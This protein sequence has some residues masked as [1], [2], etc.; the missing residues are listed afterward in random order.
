MQYSHAVVACIHDLNGGGGGGVGPVWV[1]G[2]G[3]GFVGVFLKYTHEAKALKTK[4][5]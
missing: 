4:I 3:G 1:G 5:F 2:G